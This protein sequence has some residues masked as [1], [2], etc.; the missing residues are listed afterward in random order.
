MIISGKPVIASEA[1]GISFVIKNN[2]DG[3]LCS[4]DDVKGFAE[5][6]LRLLNED[7]LYRYKRRNSCYYILITE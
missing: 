7:D 6:I 4:P 1:D 5:Y 3:I 2:I